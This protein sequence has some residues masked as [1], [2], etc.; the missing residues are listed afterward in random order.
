MADMD[1]NLSMMQ[2]NPPVNFHLSNQIL[3]Y[4][5]K[6]L[7]GLVTRIMDPVNEMVRLWPGPIDA[8]ASP[9]ANSIPLHQRTTDVRVVWMVN[10]RFLNEAVVKGTTNEAIVKK[11]DTW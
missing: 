8:L 9:K 5:V 3:L 2:K 10:S 1:Y 6:L 11:C 7:E 4:L